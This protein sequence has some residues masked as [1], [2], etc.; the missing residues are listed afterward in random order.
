MS[1][2]YRHSWSGKSLGPSRSPARPAFTLIEL[3]VVVAIIAVLAALLLPVL[4][5]AKAQA[6]RIQCVNNQKQLVIAWTT[7]SGDNREL[8]AGNGSRQSNRAGPYLWVLGGDHGYQPGFID[9]QQLLSPNYA[10]FAP[11]LKSPQTYKCPVDHS[12]LKVALREVPKIRSYSLN[13]Y[14]GTPPGNLFEPFQLSPNYKLFLKSSDLA[15]S[16]PA[17]RFVFMDVNPANLCTPAFGVSM[18]AEILIHYPSS[19]HRR[20]GVV[21]FADSH[22]EAHRW[23]DSRTMKT[24]PPSGIIAHWDPSPNNRDLKWIRE[25]T[26][27]RK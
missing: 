7:Y 23:V 1:R 4:A 27:V 17:Q 13:C 19:L 21:A 22:V 26:T 16:L 24:A 3:L 11:Y 12:A 5:R 25:R 10:L 6:L 20:V 9:P 2:R 14:V 15:A 18:D 8:L